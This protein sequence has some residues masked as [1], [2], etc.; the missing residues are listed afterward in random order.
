MLNQWSAV[1][2]VRGNVDRQGEEG[3]GTGPY[4]KVVGYSED[5][6]AMGEGSLETMRSDKETGGDQLPVSRHSPEKQRRQRACSSLLC[7]R[8]WW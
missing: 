1:L 7:Q 5:V 6:N 8:R 4:G 2:L 3:V